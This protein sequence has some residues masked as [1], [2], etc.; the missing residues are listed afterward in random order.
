MFSFYSLP[1]MNYI[2]YN[3]KAGDYINKNDKSSQK[4]AYLSLFEC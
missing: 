3:E 2:G 1:F 4:K